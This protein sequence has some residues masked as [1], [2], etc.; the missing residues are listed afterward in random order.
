MKFI[1]GDS[2]TM[3]VRGRVMPNGRHYVSIGID[4]GNISHMDTVK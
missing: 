1:K 3:G 2:E 4:F